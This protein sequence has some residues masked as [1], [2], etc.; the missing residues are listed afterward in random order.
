MRRSRMSRDKSKVLFGTGIFAAMVYLVTTMILLS[1]KEKKEAAEKFNGTLQN[2]NATANCQ[3]FFSDMGP[4]FLGYDSE[5]SCFALPQL[6]FT[7][8]PENTFCSESDE[9]DNQN[10]SQG[11]L[12]SAF[13]KS[14]GKYGFGDFMITEGEAY[15][16]QQSCDLNETIIQFNK[17]RGFNCIND[18][19]Q[20]N[21]TFFF[22]YR[23]FFNQS[24]GLGLVSWK[25]Y[26]NGPFLLPNGTAYLSHRSLDAS[27]KFDKNAFPTAGECDVLTQR[28]INPGY[29]QLTNIFSG[30][31]QTVSDFYNG[32][33]ANYNQAYCD[34]LTQVVNQS[35]SITYKKAMMAYNETKNQFEIEKAQKIADIKS[36]FLYRVV[37]LAVLFVGITG[38]A[39]FSKKKKEEKIPLS[40]LLVTGRAPGGTEECS[41][42]AGAD[43]NSSARGSDAGSDYVHMPAGEPFGG[44]VF[45]DADESIENSTI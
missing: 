8:Q 21:C 43:N 37:G 18:D 35:N 5:G 17:S 39:I 7:T 3:D 33:G 13:N 32:Y 28:Y 36:D 22:G 41:A 27:A 25:I 6:I 42:V 10:I 19:S 40:L 31:L 4:Y 12:C 2:D 30:I 15:V 24:D 26:D 29:P 34:A 23:Y 1:E 38:L 16:F 9:A 45:S 20:E 14:F 44:A 11:S